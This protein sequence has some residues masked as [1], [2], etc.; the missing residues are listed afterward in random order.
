MNVL[1]VLP[2]FP[3]PAD[4]GA[5]ADVWSR[6]VAMKTLGYTIDVLVMA[7]KLRPAS[8]HVAEVCRLVDS[9]QFIERRPLRKCIATRLPTFISRNSA[10][11]EHPLVR[12]YDVTI[13]E[14]EDT[15]A[16][17]DNPSLQTGLTVLRVHND[18][19][20]YLREFLKLEE[21]FT[22]RQFLRLEL[23]RLKPYVRAAHE[24]V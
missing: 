9:L 14:A 12:P 24:R 21:N 3:F 18:E 15:V 6:I 17:T 16:I 19:I 7:Q 13:M 23:I 11:S 22:R 20:A 10:L 5:R 4:N 8:S 2:D 1:H